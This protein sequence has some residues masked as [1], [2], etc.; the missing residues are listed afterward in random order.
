MFT[1][2]WGQFW[3]VSGN[4]TQTTCREPAAT[5]PSQT[6]QVGTGRPTCRPVSKPGCSCGQFLVLTEQS[7]TSELAWPS[8]S[9]TGSPSASPE[10]W[11][12][13]ASSQTPV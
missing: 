12:G 4:H 7:P 8:P 13:L 10:P 3:G 11:P 2:G 1:G 9:A 6:A 5:S